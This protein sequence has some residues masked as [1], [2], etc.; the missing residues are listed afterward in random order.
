MI[1]GRPCGSVFYDILMPL[2]ST[3]ARVGNFLDFTNGYYKVTSSEG[4]HVEYL[5]PFPPGY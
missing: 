3:M 1:T 5:V 4:D 2:A